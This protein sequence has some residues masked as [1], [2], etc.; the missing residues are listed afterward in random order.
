MHN[1]RNDMALKPIICTH[2]LSQLIRSL[3]AVYRW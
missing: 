3:K 1:T 2:H